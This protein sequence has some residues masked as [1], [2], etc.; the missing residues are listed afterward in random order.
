MSR[1]DERNRCDED[2]DERRNDGS[3]VKVENLQDFIRRLCR[4][5]VDHTSYYHY[6]KWDSFAKMMR[7]VEGG[8]RM[9]LLTV[10]NKTNDAIEK[11]WGD[12]VFM[13][14]FSYSR[15][16]DVA[17]WMNYGRKS[18]DAI[19]IRF[20]GYEVA[21]WYERHKNGDGFYKAVK[22]GNGFRYEA[23]ERSEIVS[24]K[25][26]DVAYVIPSWMTRGNL[27]GNVEYSRQFYR[28]LDCGSMNWSDSVYNAEQRS[29]LLPYFK[30]RGWCYERETRLVVTL[31]SATPGVE[32]LAVSFCAP[33]NELER[34]M[35]EGESERALLCGP[36]Y[37]EAVASKESV[38]GVRLK[39]IRKSDY[40]EEIKIFSEC[41]NCKF[42]APVTGGNA[43]E[44]GEEKVRILACCDIHACGLDSVDPSG[45]DIAIIAGDLMSKGSY[46]AVLPPKSH[47]DKQVAWVREK[48]IP[49]CK[50]HKETQFVIVAG[51]CDEFALMPENPLRNLPRDSNIHYLQDS[52]VEIKGVKIWG[53]PWTKPKHKR[54]GHPSE[55][56]LFEKSPEFLKAAYS[57][58]PM[59]IDVLVSHSTPSVPDSWIAGDPANKFGNETLSSC[60][61]EKDPAVCVCGHIHAHDHKPARIGKTVVFNVSLIEDRDSERPQF[62]P[63]VF[64]LVRDSSGKWACERVREN[65]LN[66]E[67]Y[68]FKFY[69]GE[70]KCPEGI[71][72]G[73]WGVERDL[74][75]NPMFRKLHFEEYEAASISSLPQVLR[76]AKVDDVTRASAFCFG[77]ASDLNDPA[78]AMKTYLREPEGLSEKE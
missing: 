14:C 63:R 33:F 1:L 59:G 75:M 35:K 62:L 4:G 22:D 3:D 32:R 10:A 45:C 18:P 16:E 9:L 41:D 65:E 70:K 39:D 20:A 21:S 28:V 69:H 50:R 25:L 53:T 23:L 19:R 36:W 17:M 64:T 13:A 12:N 68:K 46:P 74:F 5:G 48:L 66:A 40:A 61:E 42:K 8:K 29:E 51:N 27:T 43:S 54:L 26:V 73:A 57:K 67:D 71:S 60:I 2:P 34:Q 47:V 58:M 52:M 76:D 7:K 30:K 78:L 44:E 24:V 38:L 72:P 55:Y 37:D 15:Y 11:N 31:K 6:T 49:W 77:C 56:R